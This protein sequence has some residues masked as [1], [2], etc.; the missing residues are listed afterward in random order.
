MFAALD[1]E[2]FQRC[3][4]AWVEAV[5][6]ACAG[7]LAIDGKTLR[8][9]FD[10]AGGRAAIHIISAWSSSQG[11]VLGQRKVDDKS[12]PPP[13]AVRRAG[14]ITAIPELLDLLTLNGATVKHMA[15][16]LLRA[17]PHK[18]SL[19][20]K[21]KLAGWDDQFIYEVITA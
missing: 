19:R 8:R 3:F 1:A 20:L 7:V 12:N 6:E 14:G 5:H 9:S 10:R 21:R 18:H 4:I 15:S 17:A 16:D 13:E 2:R 11:L